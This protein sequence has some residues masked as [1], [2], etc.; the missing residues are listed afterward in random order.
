MDGSVPAIQSR[1]PE[2]AVIENEENIGYCGGNNAGLQHAAA[3]NM[4]Y[5]MLLNNDTEVTPDSVR[6]LVEAAESNEKVGIL[7]PTICYHDQPDVIWSAGG[8]IDWH[9]GE[10]RMIG[11]NEPNRGQFGLKTREVDFVTGCAL[12]IKRKAL[13]RIGPLDERFFAYYE[14]A[15]W[16]VRAHRAGFKIIH[17]PRARIWH[18]ISPKARSDSPLTHYYMT[19]NRLLFLQASG[20]GLRAWMHTLF[21]EYLRTIVSWSV[22]PTWRDKR[23][24]R[25][26]MLR[27][28]TDYCLQRFGRFPDTPGSDARQEIAE[29]AAT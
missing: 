13:E 21:A 10:T 16:C 14:E 8:A 19:R 27:A 9:R 23:R 12:L 6:L 11:L 15:E 28:V 22:K 17:V 18:K 5:M 2:V 3:L 20:A 24:Q 25:D 7:G 29:G 4:E 26:M 1:F